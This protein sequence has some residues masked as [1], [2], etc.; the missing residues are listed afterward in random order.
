MNAWKAISHGSL[1]LVMTALPQ[2][3]QPQN[4]TG[5]GLPLMPN[6]LA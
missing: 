1:R 6:G 3:R 2:S 4:G 5:H